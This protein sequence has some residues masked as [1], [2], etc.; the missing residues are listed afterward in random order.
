MRKLASVRRID[1]VQPIPNADAIEVVTI[2]G[3]KVVVK[4]QDAFKVGDLVCYVEI[5]SVLPPKEE[6]AFLANSRYRIR[7]IKLRG[8][9]SQGIVFPLSILP[10][11]DYVE[12]QDV[13]DVLGV[14]KYEPAIPAQLRGAVKGNFPSFLIKTDESRVQNLSKRLHHYQGTPMY[15]S[16]KLDGSSFTV[17]LKD[18]EFGVCSRNMDLK[19]DL[20]NSYWKTAREL[21]VEE[22]LHQTADLLGITG[23]IAIQGELVGP[24]IQKNRLGLPKLDIYV[25][26][27]FDISA[28]KFVSIGKLKDA[29]NKVGLKH[30]PIVFEDVPLSTDVLSYVETVNGMVHP[31]Y[32][33]KDIEGLVYRPMVEI[34]DEHGRLSFK[35]INNNYLLKHGED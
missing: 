9:V 24:G 30:V 20:N 7:T 28:R 8:Q 2:G 34:D 17:Y 31:I 23:G 15:A 29:C 13:T 4:K 5:D 1:D 26:N 19:E 33:L 22:K 6:F 21:Q 11:G 16:V 27:I 3:W 25:F 14:I 18:G 32:C 12:D 10:A 35:V